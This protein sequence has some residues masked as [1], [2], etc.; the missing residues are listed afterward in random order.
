MME[1]KVR[2]YY[3]MMFYAFEIKT[4]MSGS[5]GYY[6]KLDIEYLQNHGPVLVPWASTSFALD[7][8]QVFSYGCCKIKEA[9][10][11]KDFDGELT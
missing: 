4:N 8:A 6:D 9:Q 2:F 5:I 3:A 11:V 1:V 7:K 10:V